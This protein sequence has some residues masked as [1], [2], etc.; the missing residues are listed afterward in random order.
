[1]NDEE[2]PGALLAFPEK[3]FIRGETLLHCPLGKPLK[4]AFTKGG[5]QG[6]F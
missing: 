2:Y 4:F 3:H 5:E 6:D 1:L